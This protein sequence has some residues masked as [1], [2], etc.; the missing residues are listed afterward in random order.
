[1]KTSSKLWSTLRDNV[2]TMRRKPTPAEDRLWQRIRNHQL[3]ARF[4]RQHSINRYVADFYC[5]EAGLVIEVDGT[6]HETRIEEDIAR[7]EFL[8]QHGLKVLRFSNQQIEEQLE[9]VLESIK[10]H[11]KSP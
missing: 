3:G 10:G 4:R 1:W 5:A 2:R 6:V 8:S 9:S 7:D 11:L